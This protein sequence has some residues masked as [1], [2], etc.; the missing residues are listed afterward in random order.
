MNLIIKSAKQEDLES[1]IK[2]LSD[3][4]LP[5]ID[6]KQDNIQLFIGLL[7][8]KI[9]SSIGLE[10]YKSIGLLRSLAVKDS[11]KGQQIG[12]KLVWQMIDFC[13]IEKVSKLYL[14]TTTAEK[15]FDKFGFIKID[16]L[17]VPDI[18]KQTREF[19]DICPVSAVVMYK[20]MNLK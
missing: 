1:I 7:N 5:M 18:I 8:N 17:E 14:L 11:F 10:N 15:Y 19:K 3:N 13:K 6:I 16:R 12:A 20:N 9:I 2:L 4:N